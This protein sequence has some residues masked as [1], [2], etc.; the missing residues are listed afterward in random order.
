MNES[1][2]PEAGLAGD[3]A[4]L[5]VDTPCIH[6]GYNLRGLMTVGRC[7]ECGSLVAD[8]TRGNLLSH[9]DPSWLDKLRLG[10]SLKLWNIGLSIAFGLAAGAL[11]VAGL[12]VIVLYLGGLAAGVLGLFA[13]F[14]IT[15]QEPRVSLEEDPITLRNVIRACAVLGFTGSLLQHAEFLDPTGAIL[16]LAASA[17]TLI[18]T[19]ALIGELVYLRRFARRIPD[20][21]LEKSTTQLLWAGPIV[22]GGMVIIGAVSAFLALSAP[23]PAVGTAPPPFAGALGA[24]LAGLMCFGALASLAFLLWYVRLLTKYKAAFGTAAASSRATMAL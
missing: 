2:L 11:T 16:V 1:A 19:A 15:V 24:G 21:R 12:P 17:F 9:A 7:P 3:T 6:C 14:Y 8:S 13:T 20:A 18:G 23:A 22:I 10:A 4:S 5:D